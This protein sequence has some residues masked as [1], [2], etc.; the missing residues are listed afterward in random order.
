MSISAYAGLWSGTYSGQDSGTWSC[1]VD[2][3]GNITGSITSSY[4]GVSIPTTGTVNSSG[5]ISMTASQIIYG[6]T[7]T[8]TFTG[9]ADLSNKTNTGSW[10]TSEFYGTGFSGMFTGSMTLS[11]P[12]NDTEDLIQSS[13]S[14]TLA[15]DET[16]LTLTGTR[17]INGTGNSLNNTIIG[18]SA[19]NILRGNAGNDRLQGS[20][21]NDTLIG[22]SGQD[23]LTGGTGADQFK[24]IR[25]TEGGDTITDFS[26]TQSDKLVFVSVNFGNLVT[27]TLPTSRFRASTSG[28]ASAS[29]QRFLFNTTTGVL[30]YDPDGSGSRSAVTIT[31]LSNMNSFLASQILIVSS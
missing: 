21:G 30:K 14:Y 29:T 7:F 9:Q 25:S 8:A 17:A 6:Y 18:N 16:D 10:Q 4:L 20:G 1:T 24:W 27:G 22:G 2:A 13:V 12:T 3:S 15:A 28:L 23:R 19:A 26:R 5:N 31:T 11:S